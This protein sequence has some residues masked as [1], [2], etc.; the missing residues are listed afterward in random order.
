MVQETQT[1][2]KQQNRTIILGALALVLAFVVIGAVLM[3]VLGSG[4]ED[5]GVTAEAAKLMPADTL[6]FF[7]MNPDFTEADNFDVI[8]NAWGDVPGFDDVVDDW[9]A[10]LFEEAEDLD[11]EADIAS[12]LGDEMAFG[13]GDISALLAAGMEMSEDVMA[14]PQQLPMGDMPELPAM[15][16]AI[17]TTDTDASDAFLDKLRDE[18]T[19]VDLQES[20]Y[21]GVQ[22]VYFTP[23]DETDYDVAYATVDNYVVLAGGGLEAMQAVIDAKDGE[24]LAG[25]ES[26]K[27]VVDKLPSG[28]LGFGYA[29]AGPLMETLMDSLEDAPNMGL[30]ELGMMSTMGMDQLDAFQGG[31]FSFGFDPQGIRFDVVSVYDKDALPESAFSQVVPNETLNHVPAD[32]LIFLSSTGLGDGLKSILDMAAS[33]PEMGAEDLEE[34]MGMLEAQL[35]LK[36][37]DIFNA[38]SGEFSVALTR[39]SGLLGDPSVP[40]GL[41]VQFE[42]KDEDTFQQIMNLAGL[43]I[44]SLGEGIE[45]D[46]SDIGDVTVTLVN[47][48]DGAAM[49]GWGLSDDFFALGTSQSL[50]ETAFEGGDTLADDETFKAAT[51]PLPKKNSGYFYLNLADSLDLIYAM[52][53]DY[54]K[55]DFDEARDVLGPIK[56]ISAAGEPINREKDS[57]MS[58]FFIL[59]ED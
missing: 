1:S 13:L 49:V 27:K 50:L 20:E 56:A 38:L 21:K 17:E 46:K 25:T 16:L 30:S 53:S 3:F 45:V 9:P 26:Y 43:A 5:E 6:L 28:S 59:L 8:E 12:W 29:N 39:D 11:Y 57:S 55:A 7:S 18:M 33:M 54:E 48:P 24:N 23:E 10:V 14:N 52:M 34:S 51:A 44:L 4:S 40:I 41:L 42:N 35:G 58:T 47:G 2:N 37:D 32:T 15:I 19:D 36:V 31:G 22:I